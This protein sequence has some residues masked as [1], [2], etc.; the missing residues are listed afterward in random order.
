MTMPGWIDGAVTKVINSVVNDI[1]EA[2][3]P[4]SEDC[5]TINIVRP[6]GTKPQEKLP[7]VSLSV[8]RCN[9]SEPVPDDVSSASMGVGAGLSPISRFC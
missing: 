9:G 7:I 3:T 5:L 8:C 6:A 4:E 1:Y 2:V